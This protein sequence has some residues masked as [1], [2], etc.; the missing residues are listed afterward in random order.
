MK[1]DEIRRVQVRAE[2][3]KTVDL[4]VVTSYS[5][6]H[7][8]EAHKARCVPKRKIHKRQFLPSDSALINC[9]KKLNSEEWEIESD[10]FEE[11]ESVLR[12]VDASL[13]H[14]TVFK[15]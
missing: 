1:L 6:N 8:I 10:F 13:V 9:S 11:S 4:S 3:A 5:A 12:P 7:S 15:V 2:D 14:L